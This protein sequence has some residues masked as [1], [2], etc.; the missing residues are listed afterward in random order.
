MI[1]SEQGRGGFT[2]FWDVDDYVNATYVCRR[3]MTKL[4]RIRGGPARNFPQRR[5]SNNYY[6]SEWRLCTRKR[7]QDAVEATLA[8]SRGSLAA[9]L[10]SE[11]EPSR[12]DQSIAHGAMQRGP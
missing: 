11:G 9:L 7:C 1:H 3:V 12:P 8:A 6:F 4:E 5:R 2:D 10:A